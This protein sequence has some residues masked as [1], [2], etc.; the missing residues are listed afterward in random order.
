MKNGGQSIRQKIEKIKS[1]AIGAQLDGV[2]SKDF[3][4]A[5]YDY[6]NNIWSFAGRNDKSTIYKMHVK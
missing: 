1:N 5:F 6:K 3:T 2:F 4:L